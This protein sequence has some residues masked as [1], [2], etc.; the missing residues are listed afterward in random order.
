MCV[1]IIGGYGK[2]NARLTEILH[3]VKES[4]SLEYINTCIFCRF[5]WYLTTQ[6][7][8]CFCVTD[9]ENHTIFFF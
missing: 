8:T 3:I 4:Q 7:S 1:F 2:R 9:Y 6:Y 5:C